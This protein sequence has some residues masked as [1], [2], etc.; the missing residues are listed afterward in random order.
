MVAGREGGLGH[1]GRSRR[2][3]RDSRL[4][5]RRRRAP[6]R[7]CDGEPYAAGRVAGRARSRRARL[8][9]HRDPRRDR[10]SPRSRSS[11]GSTGRRFRPFAMT[12]RRFSSPRPARAPDRRTRPSFAARMA[13]L[14]SASARAAA[15][16]CRP[17]GSGPR[18]RYGRREAH[19]HGSIRRGPARKRSCR[20]VI[21]GPRRGRLVTPDGK[22]IVFTANEPGRG[23]RASTS[24]AIDGGKPRALTPEGYR[25]FSRGVSPDGSPGPGQRARPKTILLSARRRGAGAGPGP[26]RRRVAGRVERRRRSLYVYRR[27]D[28]R[29][30]LYRLDSPAGKKELW[31]ELMPADGSGIVDIAPIIT[32][33]RWASP[34]STASAAR[35]SD[36]VRRR[37]SSK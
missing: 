32:H 14:R 30:R 6:A 25:S 19:D 37:R 26:R 4:L 29:G 22:S 11:P 28:F 2:Q 16:R 17:T 15:R 12:G 10:A 1:G 31:K 7:A 33:S 13:R 20:R 8:D 35:S 24:C 21:S 36:I 27:R 5:A 18:S 23:S 9:P 34:T 3:S